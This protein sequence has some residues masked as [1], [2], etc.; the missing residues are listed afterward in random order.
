MKQ[1]SI[2]RLPDRLEPLPLS[3][4]FSPDNL[5]E[6]W[7]GLEEAPLRDYP[8]DEN[9][10]RPPCFARVGWNTHGL[11]VLMYALEP[12]IRSEVHSFGG[13]VWEDS[14]MEFF[15]QCAPDRT[16][17]YLNVETSCYP[18]MLIGIGPDRY[19]R[20][21]FQS[22]PEGISLKASVHRGGWWAVNYTLPALL[23]K[24]LFGWTPASGQVMR[25]N[26]YICGDLTAKPH[27]GMWQGFDPDVIKAP[28]FHQPSLFGT[29]LLTE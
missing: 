23:L 24:N 1:Y 28:D 19:S 4:E 18:A 21:V 6:P 22:C 20:T 2:R 14:C 5:P 11:H 29:M 16:Q 25:G 13:H 15:L 17:N 3:G 27:F 9:G 26:F 10:Y 12:E 8:W 7:L